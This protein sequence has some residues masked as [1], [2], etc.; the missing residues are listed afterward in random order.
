MI[1]ALQINSVY[2]AYPVKAVFLISTIHGLNPGRL[3]SGNRLIRFF[4]PNYG[5]GF[6]MLYY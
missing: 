6:A 3:S 1:A 2:L 5:C 4:M